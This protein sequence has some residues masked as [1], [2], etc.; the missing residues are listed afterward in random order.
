MWRQ[1]FLIILISSMV[2]V[3][4]PQTTIWWRTFLLVKRL[5]AQVRLGLVPGD[6]VVVPSNSN[7]ENHWCV[8]L[9]SFVCVELKYHFVGSSPLAFN[10]RK[11]KAKLWMLVF[12]ISNWF[13]SIIYCTQSSR[14][15]QTSPQQDETSLPL[16]LTKSGE[17]KPIYCTCR[18]HGSWNA[19]VDATN[20]RAK[21]EKVN[22]SQVLWGDRSARSPGRCP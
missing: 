6:V 10:G 8:L 7:E 16:T 12:I 13:V 20:Q 5:E 11:I 17:A 21:P 2:T 9:K 15:K 4:L 1:F 14:T 22:N 19:S 3:P 18:S